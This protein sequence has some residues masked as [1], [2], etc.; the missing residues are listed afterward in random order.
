MCEGVKWKYLG[1]VPKVRLNLNLFV[2]HAKC[3][4]ILVYFLD[5]SFMPF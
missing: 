3:Y 4:L 5:F 2:V 1:E